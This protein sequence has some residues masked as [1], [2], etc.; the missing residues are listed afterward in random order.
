M[1]KKKKTTRIITYVQ[2][3]ESGGFTFSFAERV[4]LDEM[5]WVKKI[6][7][8]FFFFFFSFRKLNKLPID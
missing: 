8:F 7:F 6:I 4:I 1:T 2:G 5:G 3:N